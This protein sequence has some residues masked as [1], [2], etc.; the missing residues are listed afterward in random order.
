MPLIRCSQCTTPLTDEETE[1]GTCPFCAAELER[2]VPVAKVVP[3]G[4]EVTGPGILRTL[5]FVVG[6]AV[7]FCLLPFGIM[8]YQSLPD[9]PVPDAKRDA[10]REE[11][12]AEAKKKSA[13]EPV[14]QLPAE[15]KEPDPKPKDDKTE[16]QEPT[17]IK[18]IEEKKPEE[19]KL[20]EKKETPPKAVDPLEPMRL[21][22]AYV[23]L[24]DDDAIKIDGDLGEW[25][26]VRP[27]FLNAVQ[28]GAATKKV[29]TLPKTQ[30]AYLAYCSKGL[31]VAV[32][33]VDTSGELEN[34]RKP[35]EGTWL[36]WDNDAVEVYIDT[37]NAR[38]R[39]RGQPNAHQFF[40]FPLG[41][42]GDEGIGGYESRIIAK[43]G[44]TSWNIVSLPAIG[45]NA[46]LR[47][48]KKTPTGWTLE[49][50]IPKSALRHGD[51]KPGQI[52]GFEMQID[53]G[54]NVFY[55]WSNDNPEIRPSTT[56]SAW[57]EIA[58][59]G[60]DGKIEFVGKDG[61]PIDTF[62]PGE[63]LRVRLTDADA[64]LDPAAR[65]K[66]AVTVIAKGDR[67][68]LLL[69]ETKTN[70]GVFFGVLP[71]RLS[72]R[73][74]DAGVLDVQAGETIGIEYLDLVRANGARNVRVRGEI[75]AKA[76]R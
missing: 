56:P 66:I 58:L 9:R 55:F 31:L 62:T 29:V 4:P 21:A 67:K 64:N 14:K 11:Q 2:S 19:K 1:A 37:L 63:P 34:V 53:T 30:R 70:A 23:P 12:R 13:P 72:F 38:P 45:K 39:E 75:K 18:K 52:V 5:L 36:F 26:N 71:T 49:M 35:A 44:R 40:A 69:E 48:G 51:L 54:T 47:A 16:K 59:A 7:A 17:P 50:L 61:R 41:V 6:G 42:P 15:I 3:K 73:R 24:L 46:M 43:G 27:L 10:P 22:N 76:A 57:G 65:E 32:D 74:P 68:T 28:R 8:F 33:V 20:E 60:T 25:K